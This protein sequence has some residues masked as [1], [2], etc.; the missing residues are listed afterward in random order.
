M[1]SFTECCSWLDVK[2]ILVWWFFIM[3][4]M[5]SCEEVREE[6]CAGGGLLSLESVKGEG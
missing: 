5:L 2:N 3:C 1:L 6:A 4:R